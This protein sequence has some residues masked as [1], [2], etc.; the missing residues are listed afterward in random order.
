MKNRHK[1]AGK[2]RI[3]LSVQPKCNIKFLF[4]IEKKQCMPVSARVNAAFE[5]HGYAR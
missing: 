4:C 5:L 3:C 2:S 1:A